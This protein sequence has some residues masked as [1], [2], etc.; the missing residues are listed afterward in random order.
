MIDTLKKLWFRGLYRLLSGFAFNR[1]DC[2]GE[3]PRGTVP[4]LF[5][6]LHRNG[7]LDGAVY[8]RVAP[9]AQMTLSSQLRRKAWM[10]AIF[11]GIEIVRPQDAARDGMRVSNADSFAQA[12]RHLAG[13]GELIF[14]PE[15]TS[16]LGARHLKFRTG[17]AKLAQQ[18]LA[19]VPE[20]KIVPLAAHYED[21]TVWQSNVDIRVGNAIHLRGEHSTPEIMAVLTEALEAVGL[22]CDTVEERRTVESLAYAA[23]LGN[24]DIAYSKALKALVRHPFGERLKALGA[25]GGLLR[26]QGVPLA[27]VGRV[28]PYYAALALL[29]PLQLLFGALNAVPYVAMEALAAKLSDGPNVRSL[30]R[31]LTGVPLLA[32]WGACVVSP[33]LASIDWRLIPLYWLGSIAQIKTLYRARKLL[34]TVA[35]HV[36]PI[37]TPRGLDS[38]ALI[39][40]HRE[41]TAYVRS[42][43]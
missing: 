1:I 13:G 33:M 18:T 23:T 8:R 21:A 10:R 24:R 28:W 2:T 42:K 19:H 31:A 27:P 32:L 9:R 38:R 37:V 36:A 16:E 26:H 20:L 40:L 14:F 7:A 5:V 43:L 35:N 4:T 12:S 25:Q 15:G 11:E 22:D 17:V 30:W 39:D 41:L 6:C 3:V 29:L 34:I